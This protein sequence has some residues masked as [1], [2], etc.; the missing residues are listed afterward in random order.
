MPIIVFFKKDL[1][2]FY[3]YQLVK[4]FLCASCAKILTRYSSND[5]HGAGAGAWT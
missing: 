5:L 1:C 2:R 3:S 4:I